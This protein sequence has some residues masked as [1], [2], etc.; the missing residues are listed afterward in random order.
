MYQLLTHSP[1]QP[2]NKSK[3]LG[4]KPPLKLTEIWAIRI[5]PA[6]SACPDRVGASE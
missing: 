4:Q 5:R 2:W 1:W 3:L 6:R